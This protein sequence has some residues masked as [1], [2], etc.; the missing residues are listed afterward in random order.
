M[1]TLAESTV[2]P[3]TV[4]KW[5][6]GIV[7]GLV[8]FFVGWLVST[9][10]E[11]GSH[12]ARIAVLEAQYKVLSEIVQ[13]QKAHEAR[14]TSVEAQVSKMLTRDEHLALYSQV[15]E[16]LRDLRAEQIRLRTAIEQGHA[17]IK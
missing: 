3:G 4:A 12:E 9:T 13:T 17:G 14:L 15:L 10:R 8:L 2:S 11:A 16:A 6:L 5:L 7:A 1:D